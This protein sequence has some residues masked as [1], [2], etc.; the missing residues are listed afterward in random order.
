MS[1]MSSRPRPAP[2]ELTLPPAARRRRAVVVVFTLLVATLAVSAYVLKV[3]RSDADRRKRDVARQA[4]VATDLLLVQGTSSLRGAR[5]LVDEFGFVDLDGFDA[6]ARALSGP[7]LEGV[8][9]IRRVPDVDRGLF[10]AEIGS[11]VRDVTPDGRL[12]P[13]AKRPVH[14]AVEHVAPARSPLRQLL[15]VDLLSDPEHA[16]ALEMALKTGDATLSGPIELAGEHTTGYLALAPLY[17]RGEPMA[18]AAQRRRALAGFV[19][20]GYTADGFLSAVRAALPSGADVRITD[21]DRVVAGPP[22][23]LEDSTTARLIVDVGGRTWNIATVDPQ[24]VSYG[25]PLGVMGAG[26]VLTAL[27]AIL[28]SQAA[29][30]E[31]ALEAAGGRVEQARRRTAA[32]QATTSALSRAAS[33]D[34]VVGVAFEQALEPLGTAGATVWLVSADGNALEHTRSSGIATHE[35]RAPL[36][37]DGDLPVSRAVR[38]RTSIV[39][40]ATAAVPLLAGDR[41]L[42]ALVL[43]FPDERPFPDDDAA[44]A[45]AV[46]RQVALALERARLSD[47]EH[48]LAVSLQRSLLPQALP[49]LPGVALAAMYLPS[50]RRVNLGGDWYDAL[51]LPE[52]QLGVAVGDVVGHGPR[53]AAVMGQLRSALR[54]IAMEH[55]EPAQVVEALSRFAETIPEA[56]GTT[57]VYGVFD[58]DT[59]S[60]RYACAGHPPPLLVPTDGHPEFLQGGRSL[61]L[62]VGIGGYTDATAEVPAGAL[63]VLYS[64]GAIEQRGEALDHGL[65]RL[66][67]AATSVRGLSADAATARLLEQ[68]FSGREQEDD[69]ALLTLQLLEETVP[70]LLVHEAARPERLTAVRRELRTWL[71]SAGVPE[72]AVADVVLACGEA[73]ANAVEHAHSHQNGEG[74]VTLEARLHPPGE[75]VARIRDDGRWR[76][77]TTADD[78]GRGL[79]VMRSLMGSVDVAVGGDGTVVTLRY[80]VDES[81]G[82]STAQVPAP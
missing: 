79:A 20:A 18:T 53:A 80:R 70:R 27:I 54:A 47:A 50:L 35:N 30:R 44:F 33:A 29:R 41:A 36:P 81:D 65:E 5:G 28:F 56:L 71:R 3:E 58:P 37:V 42:G 78:R 22:A 62:G 40:G 4:A 76:N 69:V 34:E 72:R 1:L 17:R 25:P 32:L 39:E 31:R 7:G 63:L 2:T 13:A 15:A 14:F 52:G 64:D 21:G 61:P 82:D 10:E 12:V 59:A 66:V 24:G 43:I 9:L 6:F 38:E 68:L 23:P 57:L 48:Q 8:L 46:G 67:D 45:L 75:I 74:S 73:L 49:D 77:W 19:A 11:S 60:L 51:A 16:T 26:I 55:D